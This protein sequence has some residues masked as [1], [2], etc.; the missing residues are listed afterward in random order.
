MPCQLINLTSVKLIKQEVLPGA[1]ACFS[2]P[3]DVLLL[4]TIARAEISRASRT[5]VGTIR[6]WV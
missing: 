4:R 5:S 1:L 2:W 3:G 6:R